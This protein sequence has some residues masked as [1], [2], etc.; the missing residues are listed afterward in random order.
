MLLCTGA[1]IGDPSMWA[2][3]VG[4]VSVSGTSVMVSG[5]AERWFGPGFLDRSPDVASR[6]L[7][8]LQDTDDAGYIQICEALAAFDVR[9]RL[10][11]VTAPV[12]AVAGSS[13]VAT[14]PDN[15]RE[16]AEG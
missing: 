11:E 5:S 16:I 12:L 6:L 4:Q 1:K 14:P 9:D 8:A 15:L 7:H 10:P 3:R 2:G 13:D